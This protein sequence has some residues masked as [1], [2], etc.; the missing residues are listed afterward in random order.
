[1][2]V[3]LKTR[4]VNKINERRKN[5]R[6]RKKIMNRIQTIKIKECEFCGKELQSKIVPI[7]MGEIIF[8]LNTGTERCTCDDAKNYWKEIDRKKEEERIKRK[9]MEHQENVH[10]LQELSKMNRRVRGYKFDNYRVTMANR[11]AY[12]KAREYAKG[13]V[14]GKKDSLYITGNI[15][16]GKTHLA[17]S[18]A[19]Y[20]IDNNIGVKFGTLINLLGVIKE[21]YKLDTVTEEHIMDLY[22]KIP[23][24]VIDDL[25]KERPSEWVLEKLFTIVNNRYE[26][27]LPI[28]ITTNYNREQLGERLA[29][30]S[31]A[32]IADSI[33]SRLYEMCSGIVIK[34]S[35]K[36]KE[37][38][39]V[40]KQNTNPNEL[41]IL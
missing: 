40:A 28:V 27:N 1:M 21:S 9:A 16:T 8:N 30:G 25:G 19:N 31:N 12:M 32:I 34:D 4:K 29:S 13:L 5:L 33:I 17:A 22:S 18:I 24:L 3:D 20:L 35:D 37:L 11:K 41:N 7:K 10:R 23:L 6:R 2:R 15:G 36:R 14:S 38:V 39:R 26:R